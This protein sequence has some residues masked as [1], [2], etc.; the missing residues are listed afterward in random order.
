MNASLKHLRIVHLAL[1]AS[2]GM[3][4]LIGERIAKEPRTLDPTVFKSIAVLAFVTAAIVLFLRMQPLSTAGEQLRLE[5]SD[6]AA[7]RRWHFLHFLS[8]ALCESIGLYGI[9]LRVM[10]AA[11][12][13]AAPFYAGAILLMLLSTPRRP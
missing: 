10:G 6:V 11:L 8:F 9:V 5:S 2:L 12:S 13:Q 1:L 3:Y 7:L 4:V